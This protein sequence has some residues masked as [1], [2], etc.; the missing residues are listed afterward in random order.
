[1]RQ[2]ANA[3][4]RWNIRPGQPVWICFPILDTTL[5]FEGVDQVAGHMG[6]AA[7][8]LASPKQFPVRRVHFDDQRMLFAGKITCREYFNFS[9]DAVVVS[10]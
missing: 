2:A 8:V 3:N 6:E 5:P 1:M 4:V 9:A 7:I 10:T